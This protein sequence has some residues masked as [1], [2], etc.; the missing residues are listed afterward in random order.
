MVTIER[1][2]E[3]EILEELT[4]EYSRWNDAGLT[5]EDLAEWRWPGFRYDE[6]EVLEAIEHAPKQ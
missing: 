2:T 6:C 4:V 1:P 3:Q 5:S